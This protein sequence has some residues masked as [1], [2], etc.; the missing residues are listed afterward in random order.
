M[1]SLPYVVVDGMGGEI[2][3]VSGYLRDLVLGDASPLTCRSYAHDLLRWFRLLWMLEVAWD[4]ASEAEAAVLVG[5][6]R[7]APNPQRRRRPGSPEP[8]SVNART[9]KPEPG[10]GYAPATIAHVLAVIAG[11]YGYHRHYGRGPLASPV[12]QGGARRR[13]LAHRSPL[14]RPARAPAGPAAPEDRAARRAVDP[15]RPVR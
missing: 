5:W 11:F 14:E 13:A 3:P 2:E 10:G 12:P 15:G 8:G 1:L 6:L 9:G 7:T 4:R